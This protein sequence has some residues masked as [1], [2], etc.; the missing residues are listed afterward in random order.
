MGAFLSDRLRNALEPL[1]VGRDVLEFGDAQ[2]ED[3]VADG[4]VAATQRRQHQGQRL[5]GLRTAAAWSKT[6]EVTDGIGIIRPQ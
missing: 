4:R 2:L 1:G 6:H 5:A 3:H